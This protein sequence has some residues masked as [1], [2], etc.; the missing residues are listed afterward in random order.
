MKVIGITGKSGSGKSTFASLLAQKLHCNHIDIDKIGHEALYRPENFDILCEK[1]GTEILDVN[2]NV[3]RKKIGN[4]VFAQ[5]DKM[6]ELT[7]ITWDYMQQQLNQILSQDDDIII[8]EWIL[9]PNSRYW[10]LCDS[11]ILVKSDDLARKNKVMERDNISE[12]YFNKRNSASI[13]YSTLQFD[14]IFENDYQT[15]AMDAMINTLST[16]YIE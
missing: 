16:Q 8:L 5:T 4:I 6:K 14:Y 1:F 10:E 2:G 11:K 9:L 15:Q 13:D 12:E 7:D 3:D